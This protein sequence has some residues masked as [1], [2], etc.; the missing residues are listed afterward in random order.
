MASRTLVL[1]TFAVVFA[2]ANVGQAD[3]PVPAK[4]AP[5]RMTLP[6][7][8]RATLFA[9]EP[10]VRQP[11]AFTFDDRGRLWVVECYSYPKWL[12]G[13]PGKDRIL[14]FEDKKGTGHFD[15]CKVFWDKG[16]NIS[17]IQVGFGGV[18]VCPIPNL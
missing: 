18:W 10:D 9:G 8:F 3:G 6:D 11:I 7:G 1:V 17:G 15:S 16:T 14:I 5:G 2:A 4:E 13:G 12:T